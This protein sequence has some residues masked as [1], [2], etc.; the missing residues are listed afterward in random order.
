MF[1]SIT[2]RPCLTSK[3]PLFLL[4]SILI[5]ATAC[6]QKKGTRK[7]GNNI[8]MAE[9]GIHRIDTMLFSTP[10]TVE[11]NP[12]SLIRKP[13]KGRIVKAGKPKVLEYKGVQTVKAGPP[14]ITRLPDNLIVV[15][16]GSD[17]IPAP[18]TFKIWKPGRDKF[19][20][21]KPGMDKPAKDKAFKIR[22]VH[23]NHPVPLRAQTPRFKDNATC[24]IRY[25]DLE[26]GMNSSYIWSVIEDKRGIIWMGTARGGLSRYNGSQ[27]I[28]YTP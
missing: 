2:R 28:H 1:N 20:Q 23:V 10:N 12:D 17:S 16:P 3:I 21:I 9:T 24:D 15:T 13:V 18:E 4:I 14:K 11:I 6:K 5:L 7:T 25:L 8:G 26:Q 19:G 22:T 27:F